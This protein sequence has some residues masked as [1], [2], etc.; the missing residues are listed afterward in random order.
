MKHWQRVTAIVA[1][2]GM[3]LA[4]GAGAAYMIRKQVIVSGACAEI[5]RYIAEDGAVQTVGTGVVT[6][7][8]L[9]DSYVAGDGLPDRTARWVN[10]LA[11][12]NDVAVRFDG[13]GGTGFVN[14]GCVSQPYAE[15]VGVLNEPADIV[16]VTG[17]L[18]DL[19]A[20]AD[21]L[22]DGANRALSAIDSDA[23]VFL[24]GPTDTPARGHVAWVDDVLAA[25]A[26]E[27]GATYVPA[28]GWDLLY[29][30]DQTHL[31]EDGHRQYAQHVAAAILG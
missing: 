20:S 27:H 6:V 26:S 9:G 13:I 5:A 11:D 16:V 28:S 2:A 30:P 21:E 22:R 19:M 10:V 23:K 24:I 15:R 3:L 1:G 8:V 18:N 31:S 25:V 7:A 14:G 29:L 12:T 17:G 4:V